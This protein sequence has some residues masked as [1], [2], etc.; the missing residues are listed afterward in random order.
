M[1]QTVFSLPLPY[2]SDGP[3]SEDPAYNQKHK[4]L[5]L[6]I[7]KNYNTNPNFVHHQTKGSHTT[8]PC[9]NKDGISSN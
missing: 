6:F 7:S 9:M 8:V 5:F 3:I 4:Q 2:I 1:P